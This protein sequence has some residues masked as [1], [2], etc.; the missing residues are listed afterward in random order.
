MREIVGVAAATKRPLL[1]PYIMRHFTGDTDDEDG[2]T[3]PV[4]PAITDFQAVFKTICDVPALQEAAV[5]LLTSQYQ[6]VCSTDAMKV[7]TSIGDL[8]TF[9]ESFNGDAYLRQK[10]STGDIVTDMDIMQRWVYDV[11]H[12]KPSLHHELLLFDFSELCKN[13]LE[14][15]QKALKDF[16]RLARE[17]L[18]DT[19]VG[20]RVCILFR[21]KL[22]LII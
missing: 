2:I 1:E 15:G 4:K 13:I 10:P 16:V 12:L 5:G 20:V 18:Y 17:W 22:T 19:S 3:V 6:Y 21:F 14:L 11:Q 8:Y 9:M 7:L